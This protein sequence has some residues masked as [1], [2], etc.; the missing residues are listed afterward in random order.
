MDAIRLFLVTGRPRKKSHRQRIEMFLDEIQ[1]VRRQRNDVLHSHWTYEHA[2]G[3]PIETGRIVA[4]KLS[5][6]QGKPD[7]HIPHTPETLHKIASKA[8]QLYSE[9]AMFMVHELGAR[10]I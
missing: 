5:K 4:K 2:P 8:H 6:K 10:H 1:E 9:M 7:T 3:T